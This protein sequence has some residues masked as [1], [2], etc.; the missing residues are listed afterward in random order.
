MDIYVVQQSVVMPYLHEPSFLSNI[1]ILPR[2]VREVRLH[3]EATP[4]EKVS[5]LIIL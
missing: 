4:Y 3:W 2:E 5:L 1:P